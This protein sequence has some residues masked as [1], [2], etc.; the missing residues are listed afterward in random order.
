MQIMS[1]SFT[2]PHCGLVS[3]I[4]VAHFGKAGPCRGCGKSVTVPIPQE[5]RL[6]AAPEAG[7]SFGS[8]L[9]A[10]AGIFFAVAIIVGAMFCVV[11]VIK[12]IQSQEMRNSLP[13]TTP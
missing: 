12:R 3:E 11:I 6:P 8:R 4:E 10:W 13:A 7:G 1:L 9:L 5:A 2:C